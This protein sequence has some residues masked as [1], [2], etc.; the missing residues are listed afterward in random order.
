MSYTASRDTSFASSTVYASHDG[1]S[2]YVPDSYMTLTSG[3]SFVTG[4]SS[5]GTG[6]ASTASYAFSSAVPT[7]S[8]G[9]SYSTYATG[10]YYSTMPAPM[11][12]GGPHMYGQGP[13]MPPPPQPLAMPMRV[14]AYPDARDMLIDRVLENAD[15]SVVYGTRPSGGSSQ[16]LVNDLIADI[17]ALEGK[18]QAA[19]DASLDASVNASVNASLNASLNVSAVPAAPPSP[20]KAEVAAAAR[21]N[22]LLTAEVGQL[23]EALRVT[24]AKA[25][26]VA[27]ECAA[28][29]AERDQMRS[30]IL[31]LQNKIVALERIASE[32]ARCRR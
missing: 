27:A 20:S 13:M 5:F 10:T 16:S 19:L 21:E 30:T 2:Y 1:G 12:Y 11:L 29:A 18:Y 3:G 26:A 15:A 8:S 32:H 7:L 23:S 24:R 14:E 25:D 17:T 22:A 9:N 31:M 4:Q 28:A 6:P